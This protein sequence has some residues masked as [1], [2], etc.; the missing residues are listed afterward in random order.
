MTSLDDRRRALEET[1]ILDFERSLKVRARRNR[2]LAEW[3]AA[4][5]GR[6][7]VDA[8]VNEV[9]TIAIASPE[10]TGLIQKIRADFSAAGR[11]ADEALIRE[12]MHELMYTAAE[13]LE[14]EQARQGY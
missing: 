7:D 3:V 4:E 1:Y 10:D 6:N 14:S 5:I 11:V 8:Y 13:A 2:L 12:K 9:M